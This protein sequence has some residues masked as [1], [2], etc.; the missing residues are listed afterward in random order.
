LAEVGEKEK[1]GLGKRKKKNENRNW[2]V[3][4]EA[5]QTKGLR[6]GQQL[7]EKIGYERNGGG[8]KN[9]TRG[10]KME[11][12]RVAGLSGGKGPE[13]SQSWGG[14]RG[15][16]RPKPKKNDRLTRGPETPESRNCREGREKKLWR[17]ELKAKK[18][19]PNKKNWGKGKEKKARK[20][21]KGTTFRHSRSIMT[22]KKRSPGRLSG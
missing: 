20:R 13:S 16:E 21:L 9:Q 14:G 10:E 2:K 8:G 7:K 6:G 11:N 19:I 1:S 18:G 15:L 4:R 5:R 12:N 17:N 3:A 22:G